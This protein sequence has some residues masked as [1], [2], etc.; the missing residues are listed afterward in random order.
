[1]NPFE[2]M[3]FDPPPDRG[4]DGEKLDDRKASPEAGVKAEATPFSLAIG[5]ETADETL[6]EGQLQGR[7]NG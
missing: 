4:G 1:M 7:S 3:G 6:I 2:L 5:A